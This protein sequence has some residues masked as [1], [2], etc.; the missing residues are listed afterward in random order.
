MPQ[1]DEKLQQI[2][3]IKNSDDFALTISGIHMTEI[4]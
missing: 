4:G 2:N 1:G 3:G